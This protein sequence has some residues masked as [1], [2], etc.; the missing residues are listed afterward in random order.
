MTME[1]VEK[2]RTLLEGVRREFKSALDEVTEVFEASLGQ[3]ED[4]L[5]ESFDIDE[6]TQDFVEDAIYKDSINDDLSMQERINRTLQAHQQQNELSSILLQQIT[7]ETAQEPSEEALEAPVVP[8]PVSL[9]DLIRNQL[10]VKTDDVE[11][12]RSMREIIEDLKQSVTA[13]E[14]YKTEESIEQELEERI[15]VCNNETTDIDVATPKETL[16]A[17]IQ[18]Q[19]LSEQ[20]KKAITVN[21]GVQALTSEGAH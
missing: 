2:Y 15:N 10:P 21:A 6:D 13:Q 18:R 5:V 17:I 3:I 4:L 11:A 14:E 7:D 20:I 16:A 8:S 12:P 9:S 19:L 1:N